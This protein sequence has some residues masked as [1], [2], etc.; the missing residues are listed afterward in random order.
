MIQVGVVVKRDVVGN[1]QSFQNRLA[2]AGQMKI[3][4][5]QQIKIVVGIVSIDNLVKNI[6][7]SAHVAVGSYLNV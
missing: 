1:F 4:V 6:S 7:A 2:T 3:I 5:L